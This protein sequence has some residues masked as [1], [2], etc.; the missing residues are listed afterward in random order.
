MTASLAIAFPIMS[1]VDSAAHP[2]EVG[3]AGVRPM[4]G[5]GAP[6]PIAVSRSDVVAATAESVPLSGHEEE[7]LRPY[8]RHDIPPICVH[9]TYARCML[10]RA[11]ILP[12]RSWDP[13]L[14][15]IEHAVE[16]VYHYIAPSLASTDGKCS[17]LLTRFLNG[18][19]LA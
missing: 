2:P 16:A 15:D 1:L 14:L 17:Q 6:L 9:Y 4:R 10:F 13:K 19:T 8:A 11:A 3:H 18:T 5:L 12:T 7:M